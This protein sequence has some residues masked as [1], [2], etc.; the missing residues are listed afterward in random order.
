MVYEE[1]YLQL[2]LVAMGM[3][4]LSLLLNKILGITPEIMKEIR[5]KSLNL[6]ERMKNAQMLGDTRLMGELQRETMQIM[7]LMAKKQ[8]IPLCLR[9]FIFIGLFA[10]LNLFYGV[11][12][13]ASGFFFGGGW[14]LYYFLLAMAFSLSLYGVKR[15]Y[16]KATGK[17]DK[18]SSFM[19]EMS[20]VLNLN[21]LRPGEG[22]VFQIPAASKPIEHQPMPLS[23][24]WKNRL[25][26]DNDN[27]ED[28]S[29]TYN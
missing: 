26:D 24:D 11:Y 13:A 27:D 5:D 4:M 28:S 25:Q 9:C 17:E 23:D 16:R 20:Q 3:V 2:F 21:S 8:L 6:Q 14:F 22:T 15:A 7:K 1:I 29:E 12:D 10:V 19:K 18:R